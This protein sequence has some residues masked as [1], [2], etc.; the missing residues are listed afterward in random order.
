MAVSWEPDSATLALLSVCVVLAAVTYQLL[1]PPPLAHPVLLG[2]Q[3][4]VQS[5]ARLTGQSA[6]YT[7]AQ[8]GG[9]RPPYRPDAKLRTLA[10]ILAGSTAALEGNA[11]SLGSAAHGHTLAE[12]VRFVR[13]ALV[14]RIRS[15]GDRPEHGSVLVALDDPAGQSTVTQ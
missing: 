8:N 6:V 15:A 5:P 4:L 3:A 7:T 11:N 10:D 1:P 2:R 9:A 13:A 12:T 14:S